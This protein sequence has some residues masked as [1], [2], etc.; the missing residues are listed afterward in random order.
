MGIWF[1]PSLHCGFKIVEALTRDP[2]VFFRLHWR[3]FKELVAGGYE[4]QGFK[5]ILTP[6]SNDGGRDV[7]ATRDDIGAIRI[8]DQVKHYKRGHLVD[9][10]EVRAMSGVLNWDRRASKACI[11]TTSDFARG[12][13]KEFADAIPTRIELR[14]GERVK[15]WL[16]AAAFKK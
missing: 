2:D 6:R 5:V 7:I 14:N 12:A 3:Q 1:S 15:E 10:D 9:I 4:K 11:S 16:A 13:Y 8:L